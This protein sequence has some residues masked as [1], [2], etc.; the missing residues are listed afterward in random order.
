MRIQFPYVKLVKIVKN[1]RSLSVCKSV[2]QF[3]IIY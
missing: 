2:T 1:V 3:Q